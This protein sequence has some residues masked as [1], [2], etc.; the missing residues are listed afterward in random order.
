MAGDDQLPQQP[1][2]SA[3]PDRISRMVGKL[4][5]DKK[6]SDAAAGKLMEMIDDWKKAISKDDGV[7]SNY[8]KSEVG[9]ELDNVLEPSQ[10]GGEAGLVGADTGMGNGVNEPSAQDEETGGGD[11]GD[12]G[13]DGDSDGG[14]KKKKEKDKDKDKDKPD[15]EGDS[16]DKDQPNKTEPEEESPAGT[17]PKGAGAEEPEG[18]VGKVGQPSETPTTPTSTEPGGGPNPVPSGTATKAGAETAEDVAKAGGMA[19]AKGAAGKAV[20]YLDAILE[21]AEDLKDKKLDMEEAK[22]LGWTVIKDIIFTLVGWEFWLIVLAIVLAIILI[23]SVI[24]MFMAFSGKTV[25]LAGGSAVIRMD[26]KDEVNQ[27]I[28]DA[29]QQAVGD[30]KLVFADDRI[31]K[32]IEWKIKGKDDQPVNTDSDSKLGEPIDVPGKDGDK[33]LVLDKRVMATLAYLGK[34]WNH[35]RV[36]V[37][38]GNGPLLTRRKG[39]FKV[40]GIDS[41]MISRIFRLAKGDE[42]ALTDPPLDT[43]SGYHTGQAVG[44]D[45]VGRVSLPLAIACFQGRRVPVQVGWQRVVLEAKLRPIYEQFQVDLT[46]LTEQIMVLTRIADGVKEDQEAKQSDTTGKRKDTYTQYILG[47]FDSEDS[48]DTKALELM[49]YIITNLGDIKS[50][51]GLDKRTRKWFDEAEDKLKEAKQAVEATAGIE[52]LQI[53]GLAEVKGPIDESIKLMFRA[54]QVAN[55]DKWR[56]SIQAAERGGAIGGA[57]AGAPG[58][59]AGALKNTCKYWQSYEARQHVRQLEL[60]VLR[61]PTDPEMIAMMGNGSKNYEPEL[62]VKQLIVFS[63]EDDLDNGPDGYDVFPDG[64]VSVDEGGLQFDDTNKDGVVNDAD[65][66]FMKLPVDNGV[67]SKPATIFVYRKEWPQF[68][69]TWRSVFGLWE[70]GWQAIKMA[71]EA[72]W[73]PIHDIWTGAGVSLGANENVEKVSYKRFVHIGF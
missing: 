19:A 40:G 15:K 13:G 9:K 58:A 7:L 72:F 43:I 45:E 2:D 44:I 42:S 39:V 54:M 62:A 47:G 11:G 37:S 26:A 31:A 71:G 1:L 59:V 8:I 29:V 38:Y 50:T 57:I 10:A 28:Y 66:H 23:I 3:E 6:I 68:H 22:H 36:G 61:M 21:G 52:R 16:K 20:P 17:K 14:R 46:D 25:D 70:I 30:K 49:G 24:G 5:D 65:E 69:I 63:P 34:K 51:N 73:D 55:M 48:R 18:G 53:W 67:L 4:I 32:D 12:G 56:G 60:D 35:I 33:Y 41:E 27:K 64:A